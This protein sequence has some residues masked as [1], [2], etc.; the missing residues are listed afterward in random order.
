MTAS[1]ES[2]QRLQRRVR[3]VKPPLL[4]SQLMFDLLLCP[5]KQYIAAHKWWMYHEGSI[6]VI[7]PTFYPPFS[8][9]Q[10]SRNK[11]SGVMVHYVKGRQ[12]PARSSVVDWYN[13]DFKSSE[14]LIESRSPEL[15]AEV[16]R[17]RQ[18]AL[19]ECTVKE[20]IDIQRDAFTELAAEKLLQVRF[21][22]QSFALRCMSALWR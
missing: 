17:L 12:F 18:Q 6:I 21:F 10:I 20:L 14:T 2:L 19:E 3:V 4:P 5:Q 7:P 1:A 16:K 9:V 8:I 11:N 22:I 15:E 13:P